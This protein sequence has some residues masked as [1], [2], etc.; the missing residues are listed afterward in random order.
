MRKHPGNL[1]GNTLLFCIQSTPQEEKQM[2]T[3]ISMLALGLLVAFSAPA[4]AGTKAPKTEADCTKA[5][6]HWD[7]A[8]KKCSKG[9]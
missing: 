1:C 3:L 5:K 4:F 2:K 6:M 9:M 7:A 8:T